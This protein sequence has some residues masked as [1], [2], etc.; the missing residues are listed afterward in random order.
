[1]GPLGRQ[2]Q[3]NSSRDEGEA[4]VDVTLGRFDYKTLVG[5]RM[6]DAVHDRDG[7]P[8]AMLGFCTAARQLAPRDR[9]IGWTP[10]LSEKTRPALAGRALQLTA[11][12]YRLLHALSLDTGGVGTYETLI[13]RVWSE[14]GGGNVEALRSA[15]AKLRREFGD[16]ARKPRYVLGVRGLGYR[17][18][19]ADGA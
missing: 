6:G 16:D 14:K 4:P 15:V 8:I 2:Q 3:V 18:P 9:F 1:M 19:E 12:K 17:M 11:T 10:Q 5:A 7:R 13:R